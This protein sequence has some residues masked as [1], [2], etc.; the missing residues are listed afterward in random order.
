MF[1]RKLL[2][3]LLLLSAIATQAQKNF[4]YLP[5][6]PKPGDVITF[7]YEPAGDIANTIL[8]VEGVIYQMGTRGR[9]A[10][11]LV[12]E[13]KAGKYTGSF[14][15]DTAMSFVYLGFTADKKFD[16]N[17]N[18]GYT[19]LLYENNLPR[20]GGYS[21]KA[22][23]YQFL[24]SQQA[25]IEASNEKALAAMEKEIE[26]NPDSRKA[27]LNTYIRLQTI[28]NKDEAANIVQKEIESLQKVGMK[29]ERD[30]NNL[31]FDY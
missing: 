28:V 29:D 26:L 13:K 18:E 12:M 11:D 21:S 10:D 5:E 19:I 3:V 31:E 22:T 17:F 8:P 23:F 9:K 16:N 2:S 30:N 7:T 15:T 27:F 4:S 24:G 1:T 20:K 25:G 6:N 14:T